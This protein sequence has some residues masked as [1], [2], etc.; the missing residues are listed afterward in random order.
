MAHQRVNIKDNSSTDDEIYDGFV[1]LDDSPTAPWSDD[2]A[3]YRPTPPSLVDKAM[4]YMKDGLNS[5]ALESLKEALIA[6]VGSTLDRA[7]FEEALGALSTKV[8]E[9]MHREDSSSR[10]GPPN[11]AD[12]DIDPTTA[13]LSK[14]TETRLSATSPRDFL[15]SIATLDA[16]KL[17]D[18]VTKLFGP[19]PD[20]TEN[21]SSLQ[22]A[23]NEAGDDP[24]DDSV[25]GLQV[26]DGEDGFDPLGVSTAFKRGPKTYAER[27]RRQKM[28]DQWSTMEEGN[29]ERDRRRKPRPR[30]LVSADTMLKDL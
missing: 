1:V 22:T 24:L 16:T 13:Y 20:T 12:D 19:H 5:E 25:D 4:Q 23:K 7:A 2:Q 26:T 28:F 8:Q 29:L 11:N 17:L 14:P 21:R 18:G 10:T 9:A 30:S 27:N 15:R 3:S 6:R